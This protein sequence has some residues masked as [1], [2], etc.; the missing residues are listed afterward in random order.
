MLDK[1]NDAIALQQEHVNHL[2][3]A[4]ETALAD[5]VVVCSG[6][7]IARQQ[8]LSANYVL[9]TA[10]HICA[11]LDILEKYPRKIALAQR[12]LNRLQGLRDA[13]QGPRQAESISEGMAR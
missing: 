12:K 3:I 5:R 4:Y 8:P 2:T 1:F 13:V 10:K 11:Y 7:T 9:E 6:I